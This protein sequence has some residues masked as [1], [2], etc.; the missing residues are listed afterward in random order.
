MEERVRGLCSAT[1]A[2]NS[3]L[4]NGACTLIVQK[5]DRPVLYL[6]CRHHVYE[7]VL[8]KAFFTCLGVSSGPDIQ[9]SKRF[10]GGWEFIDRTTPG[11]FTADDVP[12]RDKLLVN[13]RCFLDHS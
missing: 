5:L 8:E 1:T 2:V 10:Q 3:E 11:P 13:F 6:A 4:V 7:L 12:D 9:L